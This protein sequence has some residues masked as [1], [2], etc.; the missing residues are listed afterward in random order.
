M[1]HKIL[2]H[3]N[4]FRLIAPN[5]WQ[6]SG[7]LN[8]PLKRNMTIMKSTGGLIIYSAIALTDEGMQKLEKLG[9]PKSII[10][11]SQGHAMDLP[12]YKKRYPEIHVA[13][14]DNT[15]DMHGIRPD[16]AATDTYSKTAILAKIVPGY[17]IN[18]VYLEVNVGKDKIICLCDALAGYNAYRPSFGGKIAKTIF[19]PKGGNFGVAK[20]V[21]WAYIKDKAAFYNWLMS[22][23]DSNLTTML[24]A[25]GEPMTQN[26]REELS[27]AASALG[28]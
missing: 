25:H 9:K 5:V 23:A 16:S 2:P 3:D 24:F 11:P 8:Y 13:S 10:V 12:F 27:R 4:D 6:I 21:K 1:L 15:T 14:W 18:E 19:G 28:V 26:F 7:T 17:K 20:I 22:L